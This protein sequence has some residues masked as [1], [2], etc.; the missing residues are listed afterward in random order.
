MVLL[1]MNS[2][3]EIVKHFPHGVNISAFSVFILKLFPVST[4]DTGHTRV[5]NFSQ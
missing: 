1:S 5:I 4:D 3:M 2:G